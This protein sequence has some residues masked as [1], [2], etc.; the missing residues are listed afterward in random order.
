ML[1]DGFD[2]IVFTFWKRTLDILASVFDAANMNYCRLDGSLTAKK[3]NEVLTNFKSNPA[4]KVLIMTFST[5]A[6]GY[7]ACFT[8]NFSL[9]CLQTSNGAYFLQA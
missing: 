6:I 4:S 3:R 2:S 1:T 8:F 5:G 9:S 7:S